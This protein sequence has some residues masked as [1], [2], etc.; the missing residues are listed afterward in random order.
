MRV[1]GSPARP[2]P[3]RP[4][5][6]ATFA[7][8]SLAGR[9]GREQL[10]QRGQL[11]FRWGHELPEVVGDPE[12]PAGSVIDFVNRSPG[13]DRRQ[14]ELTR[15]RVR[16]QNAEVGDDPA[17]ASAGQAEALP[18]ARSVAES[19]RRHEV[20][21]IDE[22]APGLPDHDDDFLAGGRDL[23]RAAR[24]RQPDGRMGV[25]GADHR[26]VDVAELV[27]LRRA[28]E[29]DVDP[30]RLQP[31]VE[32]LWH[33]DHGVRR[34]GQDP[35]ADRKRQRSRLGADGARLVDQNEVRRVRGPGQVGRLAGQADAHEAGHPVAQTARGR[36]RHHLVGGVGH[37]ASLA[38]YTCSSS[39]DPNAARSLLIASHAT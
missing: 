39:Q 6:V 15:L 29:A 4:V 25:V 28:E 12:L 8:G 24:A 32:D 17:R 2:A 38:S 30:A 22:R 3:R 16:P 37:R 1:R 18:A 13:V 7:Q 19:D 11:G 9:H 35:V 36:D 20:D 10:A 26:G 33:A 5:S 14:H 34:L 27:Q 31:V 23:G 21:P